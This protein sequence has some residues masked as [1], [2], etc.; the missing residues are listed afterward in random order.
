MS[1][2]DSDRV[3]Y[4]RDEA[5]DIKQ[6]SATGTNSGGITGL[7]YIEQITADA[8]SGRPSGDVD[9]VSNEEAPTDAKTEE[10]ENRK[11]EYTSIAETGEVDTTHADGFI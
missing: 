7:N 6:A 10:I 3:S 11:G 4:S 5:N 8:T 2:R 1:D 9:K